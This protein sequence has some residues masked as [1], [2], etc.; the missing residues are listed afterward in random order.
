MTIGSRAANQGA[1]IPRLEARLKVTGEARYAAALPLGNLAFAVLVTSSI[2]MGK[3]RTI[4]MDAA[5]RSRRAR[6]P[7]L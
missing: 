4:D 7:Q 2:A 5:R 6:H 3:V 1:P